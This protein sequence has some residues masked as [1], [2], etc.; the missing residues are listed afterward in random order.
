M[1]ERLRTAGLLDKCYVYPYDESEPDYFD[2]IARLCDLI[3]QGAPDLKVLQTITPEGANPLWGKV[4]AWICPGAPRR[5]VLEQRR[6][7]GDEIWLYNMIAAIENTP[8]SHRLWMW[9]VL[10]ADAR[11]GLLWSAN[12]WHKTNPWENPT[13]A[14]YP[15]GRQGDQLYRYRAGEASLFYPDP[16]GKGPLVPSLRLLLIR[17]GVEDFDI[18]T[19]LA[20]AWRSGEDQLSPKAKQFDAVGTARAALIAPVMLSASKATECTARAE[21]LRLLAGNELEAARQAPM[22]ICYPTRDEKGQI[23]VCGF[24]EPGTQLTLDGAAVT[25]DADGRFSVPVPDAVLAAGLSWTAQNGTN[26]K[27]WAWPGLW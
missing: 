11:G 23:A 20:Q 27:A 15:V 24:A 5:D 10:K 1:A 16:A 14:P 25:L 7:G 9:R 4:N 8:L 22:V 21:T 2:K 17:Q 18:V 13:A 26:R 12:W 19:E 3:H 6:A